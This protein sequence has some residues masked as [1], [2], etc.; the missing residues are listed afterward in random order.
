MRRVV[1]VEEKAKAHDVG[2]EMT[3]EHLQRQWLPAMDEAFAEL[4]LYIVPE[5]YTYVGDYLVSHIPGEPEPETRAP[6]VILRPFI[7]GANY[8]G[9]IGASCSQA[10]H[11][12]WKICFQTGQRSLLDTAAWPPRPDQG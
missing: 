11:Q 2:E 9:A 1:V 3:M 6:I 4:V 7:I 12:L 5:L 10:T 8:V